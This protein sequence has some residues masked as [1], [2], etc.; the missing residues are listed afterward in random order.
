MRIEKINQIF[1][2]SA[3]LSKAGTG[4]AG[5][6]YNQGVRE[7]RE[8][9]LIKNKFMDCVIQGFSKDKDNKDK[10]KTRQAEA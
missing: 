4:R 1:S 9:E 2:P 6:A 5:T 3:G 10:N 7:V 8:S